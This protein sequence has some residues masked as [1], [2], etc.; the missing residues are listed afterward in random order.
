MSERA[1]A[2]IIAAVTVGLF[3]LFVI[4]ADKGLL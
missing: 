4:A 2:C 1:F 3:I